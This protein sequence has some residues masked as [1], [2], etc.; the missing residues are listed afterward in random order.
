MA[1]FLE[2]IVTSVEEAVEAEAGGANRLELVRNLEEG[3][4]TPYPHIVRE[5]LEAVRIPVRVMLRHTPDMLLHE[6]RDAA[7]LET[8]AA[9]VAQLPINGFV[10]GFLKDRSID[11]EAMTSLLPATGGRPITFHRAFDELADPL[12]ALDELKEF[13]QIDRILT[14]GGSGDWSERKCRL[15]D[16]QTRASPEII[17]LVGAGLDGPVLKD[18]AATRALREVHVGR[19]ARLPQEVSGA[20]DRHTVQTLKSF[21]K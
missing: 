13:G 21:L 3:G 7:V 11:R 12:R 5:V 20:V 19:A 8:A 6:G 10:L 4:L 17:L 14:A 9:E 16:W 1:D 15:L 18:L 2:V